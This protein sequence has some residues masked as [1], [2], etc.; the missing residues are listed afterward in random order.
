[1]SDDPFEGY[2][3]VI[4]HDGDNV[5]DWGKTRR[6]YVQW[7]PNY[8][9]RFFQ[10]LAVFGV[11]LPNQRILDLGT[12]TGFLALR[13]A[14][15]GSH[16]V[17]VDISKEQLDE[18]RTQ[19]SALGLSA[20]FLECRAEETGL[21]SASFDIITAGQSWLYFEKPRMIDETKRLL[22]RGGLL[23][24]SH[25]S[26]L[27]RQDS[28]AHASET[29]VLKHNPKWS[30]A[31][32]SGDVPVMRQWA[33]GH[34]HLHAM[35]AF[36]EAIPFTRESWRGRIRACRAVGATL[37]AEHVAAFDREHEALLQQIAGERFSV[38]HRMDAH[39]FRCA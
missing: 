12:G 25:L 33:E 20:Q 14:Q 37:T 28:I 18:A 22:K 34:F 17:G 7:R 29:L 19:A 15:V 39:I 8:P 31:D 11:G 32:F 36:D 26:W 10:A 4:S 38:L 3:R 13:F 24:T 30:A 1:V 21:P 27:P 6:D 2:G 16:V 5:I 35:F 9:D 23:M